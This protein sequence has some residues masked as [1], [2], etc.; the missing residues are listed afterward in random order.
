MSDFGFQISDK[1]MLDVGFRISDFG[2]TDVG[3]RISDFGQYGQYGQKKGLRNSKY[4]SCGILPQHTTLEFLRPITRMSD[5]RFRISDNSFFDFG[6][7][8][9][10]NSLL[11][12]EVIFDIRNPKSYIRNPI[13]NIRNRLSSI[14]YLT[15]AIDTT[16]SFFPCVL[17]RIK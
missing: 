9:S 14:V 10:D 4:S 15:T 8:I 16:T 12:N 6:F 1:L 3:C 13:S 5:F 17:T 2:Q 11:S 7:Q